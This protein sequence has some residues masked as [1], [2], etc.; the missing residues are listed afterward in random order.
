MTSAGGS[1]KVKQLQR[2]YQC[3]DRFAFRVSVFIKQILETVF[4]IKFYENIRGF[5]VEI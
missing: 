1:A 4:G 3:S 2:N 5:W